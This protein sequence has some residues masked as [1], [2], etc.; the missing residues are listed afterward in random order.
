MDGDSLPGSLVLGVKGIP[1]PSNSPGALAECSD[2][3]MD[4]ENNFWFYGAGQDFYAAYYLWRYNPQTGDW[5]WMSGGNNSETHSTAPK[6][7]LTV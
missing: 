7:F 1:A 5:T 3:W 6:V 4:N 2:Y